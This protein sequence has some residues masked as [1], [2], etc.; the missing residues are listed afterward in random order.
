MDIAMQMRR[1]VSLVFDSGAECGAAAQATSDRY[2]VTPKFVL[3]RRRLVLVASWAPWAH[4]F[5]Q[6]S[7]QSEADVDVER[8]HDRKRISSCKDSAP[9]IS[10]QCQFNVLRDIF[11]ETGCLCS[12]E[13]AH[14]ALRPIRPLEVWIIFLD[15]ETS[16]TPALIA[17]H[18]VTQ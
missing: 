10:W 3:T 6:D 8:V 18:L 1:A 4:A 16:S 15:S 17:V 14:H 13:A 11:A 5:P 12:S 9:L 7:G 2:H